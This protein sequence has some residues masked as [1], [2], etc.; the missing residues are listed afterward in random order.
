MSA[1]RYQASKFDRLARPWAAYSGG[2]GD[3]GKVCRNENRIYCLLSDGECDEGS[4]WEAILFS[5]H[6]KLDN[7]W[8]SSISIRSKAL[9]E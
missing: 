1:T 9:E 7:L 6:H 8:P 2:H 3:C 5:P 4:N